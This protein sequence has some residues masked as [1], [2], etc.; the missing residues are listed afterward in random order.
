MHVLSETYYHWQWSIKIFLDVSF[1]NTNCYI[2]ICGKIIWWTIVCYD[3]RGL[4]VVERHCLH[5]I[6]AFYGF[7][8]KQEYSCEGLIGLGLEVQ[9]EGHWNIILAGLNPVAFVIS[10]VNLTDLKFT[11]F[12]CFDQVHGSAD[13]RTKEISFEAWKLISNFSS[14]NFSGTDYFFILLTN[15]FYFF[16]GC[17][18]WYLL[19][20]L[21]MDL[22]L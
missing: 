17:S 13:R 21:N 9:V 14:F 11:S 2:S 6:H 12:S 15:Y 3:L 16:W 8:F 1:T 10:I 7:Q 19:F 4:A 18:F 5:I 20:M 22:S